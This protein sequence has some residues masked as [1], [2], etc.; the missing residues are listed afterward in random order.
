MRMILLITL[1]ALVGCSSSQ[2]DGAVPPVVDQDPPVVNLAPLDE[3]QTSLTFVLSGTVE[4]AGSGVASVDLHVLAP[5][6]VWEIYGTFPSF[7]LNFTAT[8]P[9]LHHFRVTALDQAGNALALDD[10]PSVQTTVPEPIII[11]DLTGED[12]DITNAVLRYHIGLEG[13]DHGLGRNT[14]RP[15]NHPRFAFAGEPGF[16]EPENLTDI[17]AVNFGGQRRAYP[18][19]ELPDR[20]VVNDTAGGVHLAATY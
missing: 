8:E 2:D 7:P 5:G 18:I 3:D 20:E 17:M 13:W 19:G 15:I 4:D 1:L 16:P 11:T 12:F 9:G 10:A 6:G 14:I